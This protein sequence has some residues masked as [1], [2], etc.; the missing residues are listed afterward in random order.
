MEAEQNTG[1]L[2]PW[3]TKADTQDHQVVEKCMAKSKPKKQTLD[4]LAQTAKKHGH[5]IRMANELKR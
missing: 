5:H 3:A 2:Q 4:I 1:T